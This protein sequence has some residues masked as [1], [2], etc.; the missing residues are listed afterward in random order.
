MKKQVTLQQ[1]HVMGSLNHQTTTQVLFQQSSYHPL[2][3]HSTALSQFQSPVQDLCSAYRDSLQAHRPSSLLSGSANS[4]L[5]S[6][7]ALQA[8][9]QPST[10]SLPMQAPIAMQVAIATE[11]RHCISMA[12]GS[13]YFSGHHSYTAGCFD[14]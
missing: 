8:S 4:S 1:Q 5:H 13:S 7:T 10:Q 12:Y 6:F 11:P 3:Q 2:A 14:R 9:L